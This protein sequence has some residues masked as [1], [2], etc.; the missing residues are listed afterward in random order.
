MRLSNSFV[1][2]TMLCLMFL[3]GCAGYAPD[4]RLIGEKSEKIIQVLGKPSSELKSEGG[5]VLIFPRGP[6]GKHTYFVYLDQDGKAVRWTQVLDEKNFAL[7]KP[8]MHRD[9]VGAIIGEAKDTYGLGRNRGYVWNYR[10]VNSHCL[11]FNIEFS[12][13]D[14]VRY[15]G[16]SKPPECRIRG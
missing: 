16:Y 3:T 9:E 12:K 2:T 13:D 1:A 5:S 11:W 15:T 14:V 4:D 7:I 8:D 10:Y 6:R